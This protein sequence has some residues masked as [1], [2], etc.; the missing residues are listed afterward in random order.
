M[1][2]GHEVGYR[3]HHDIQLQCGEKRR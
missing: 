1:L 2:L 3:Q